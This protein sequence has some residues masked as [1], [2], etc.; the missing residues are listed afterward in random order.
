MS[1]EETNEQP[2]L[3][4][5]ASL[6][7]RRMLLGL[8]FGAANLALL[9]RLG[10]RNP[11]PAAPTNQLVTGSTTSTTSTTSLASLATSPPILN[12]ASMVDPVNH[13]FDTVITA[14]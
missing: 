10:T 8:G 11:T 7:R 6:G 4:S 2:V 3:P 13:V 5:E 1:E 9:R 12:A 14:G